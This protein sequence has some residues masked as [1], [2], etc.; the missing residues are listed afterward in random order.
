MTA[1]RTEVRTQ[2][3][4]TQRLSNTG[5]GNPRW[6]LFTRFGVFDT[7]PDAQCNYLPFDAWAH[8]PRPDVVLTV[9]GAGK[10]IRAYRVGEADGA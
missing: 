9:N 4:N 1:G 10:V 2:I 8:G 7:N 5:S 3:V 6:R